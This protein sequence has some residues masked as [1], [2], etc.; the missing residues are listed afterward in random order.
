MTAFLNYKKIEL[1]IDTK[2]LPDI[3]TEERTS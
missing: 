3:M 2:D 1:R